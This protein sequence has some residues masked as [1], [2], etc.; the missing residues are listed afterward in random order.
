MKAM[1]YMLLSPDVFSLPHAYSCPCRHEHQLD[2]DPAAGFK[3][4]T[5]GYI[6]M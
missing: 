4:Q 1:G 2:V 5:P 6:I 3:A